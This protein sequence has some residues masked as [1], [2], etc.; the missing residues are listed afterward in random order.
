MKRKFSALF[1]EKVMVCGSTSTTIQDQKELEDLG[2]YI[3]ESIY[4]N[5][6]MA[7]Y[8]G[9]TSKLNKNKSK[10]YENYASVLTKK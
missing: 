10:I 3:Q 9:Y 6:G 7:V 4:F 2:M 5:N 1:D 8:K